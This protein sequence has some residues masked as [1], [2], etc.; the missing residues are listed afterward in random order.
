MVNRSYLF[1]AVLAASFALPMLLTNPHWSQAMRQP[2]DWLQRAG[3]QSASAVSGET[4]MGSDGGTRKAP[5]AGET[6]PW[7]A[8]PDVATDTAP[9]AI[10]APRTRAVTWP[11]VG[12]P[13][14]QTLADVVRFDA[15]PQWM[16][17]N[18]SR[19]A[20]LPF[21]NGWQV[22]RVPLATG[23]Q[24][25][26]VCG[27]LTYVFDAQPSVQRVS[28]DG[29][30]GDPSR[31]IDTAVRFWNMA[32]DATYGPGLYLGKVGDQVLGVL[33][34]G[35][36]QVMLADRP[37]ERY[38]LKLELNRAGS[39]LGLSEEMTG[40]LNALKPPVAPAGE[41]AQPQPT[42]QPTAPKPIAPEQPSS[43]AIR[44]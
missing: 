8:P 40:L 15:T 17:G 20:R 33:Q 11:P 32:P 23:S 24:P 4:L 7:P 41:A 18:W 37:Q 16:M 42:G 2:V 35:T 14:A 34:V 31:V 3:K 13:P 10:P 26:D 5:R 25:F 44:G 28:F 6:D 21:D 30:T 36:A 1:V 9:P 22:Y 29:W 12:G 19:V 38:Q 39:K 27:S 43:T